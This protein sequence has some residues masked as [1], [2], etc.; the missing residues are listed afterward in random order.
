MR[1]AS[2]TL[3]SLVLALSFF[4][5]SLHPLEAQ[6]RGKRNAERNAERV[7]DQCEG[8][9]YNERIRMSIT[10]FSVSHRSARQAFGDEISTILSN[11]L[12]ETNCYQI[13]SSVANR[14]DW[15]VELG[16][17]MEG[18]TL[19]GSSPEAGQAL[20]PQLIVTGEITEYQDEFVSVGP[21]GVQ[22]A[23]IGFVLQVVNPQT[24]QILLSKSFDK[25][26][27]K[28]GAATGIRLFGQTITGVNLKTQAMAD[29]LEEALLEAAGVLVNEKDNLVS[30]VGGPDQM[31][32]AKV[33]NR[34]NCQALQEGSPS[35]M[36]IIPEVH[37][38]RPAPDPAGETEIIRKLIAAG[39]RVIDPSVYDNIRNNERVNAAAKD[40][41][42]A[43]TLGAEFGA[44][45]IIIGE[46][47]SEMTNRTNNNMFSCRARVEAR[48]VSTSNARILGADGQHAGGVDV[49][50]LTAAKVALRNAGAS[51]GDYFLET[52]CELGTGGGEQGT[53]SLNVSI[54]NASFSALSQLERAIRG[55]GTV[56]D[57][58]KSLSGN[59]GNLEVD[60]SGDVGPIADIIAGGTNV[61]LE[62]T[63]FS[64]AKISLIIK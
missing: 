31:A 1:N 61:E 15:E 23:Q 4:F 55:H 28:P 32:A 60:Y 8:I 19:T 51:M 49:S 50:E 14:A 21:V 63:E 47:F 34:S 6:R 29:I 52:F 57:V 43:A 33:Y 9:P 62:I 48:A 20:G 27:N 36:V 30:A 46:A 22:R 26:K 24:R 11:A 59:I 35:V 3:L 37:I 17:G 64:D 2:F 18:N 56:Q 39:F 16:Y 54:A 10:R 45:I 38:S 42:E 40:A 53:R 13:L 25:R 7:L 12:V 41:G 58:R 44:D 5:L